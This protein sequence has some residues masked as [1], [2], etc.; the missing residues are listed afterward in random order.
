MVEDIEDDLHSGRPFTAITNKNI[1]KVGNQIRSNCQ[2]IIRAIAE[3]VGINK[4]Y[5]RQ[6]LHNNFKM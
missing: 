2:L 3:T 1:E 5:V 6:I 4:E